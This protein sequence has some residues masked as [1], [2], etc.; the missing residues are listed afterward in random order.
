MKQTI[1]EILKEFDNEFNFFDQYAIYT[2]EGGGIRDLNSIKEFIKR[3][4]KENK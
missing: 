1:D 4:W 3:K 2:K